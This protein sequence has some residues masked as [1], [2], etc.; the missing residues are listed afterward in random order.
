MRIFIECGISLNSIHNTG[1]QR[2]VRNIVRESESVGQQL[3]V[4]CIPVMFVS[5]SFR[6]YAPKSNRKG[7]LLIVLLGIFLK[8]LSKLNNLLSRLATKG[9]YSKLIFIKSYVRHLYFIYQKYHEVGNEGGV[10]SDQPLRGEV[11][12]LLDS[13]WDAQIWDA[14][15]KFRAEGGH[16]CA[17]LYDLI[18]FSHPETVEEHT[19]I[20]HTSWWLDAPLHIDSVMCISKA[21]RDD[22]FAWQ[23]E[24]DLTRKLM[25]EKVGYFHLGADLNKTDLVVQVLTSSAPNFLVVGSLEPRKNHNLILDAFEILWKKKYKINLVIVGAS[26]WKSEQLLDRIQRH[27]EIGHRLFIIRDASDRDLT[28]LY[29]KSEALIIASMVEGFG[30][31][32]VEAF[33]HGTQVICSDIPVFRE[34]AGDHAVYFEPTN[35]GALANK[36]SESV[37]SLRSGLYQKKGVTKEWISWKESTEQLLTR[38]LAITTNSESSPDL[39]GDNDLS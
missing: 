39:A 32:I 37:S 36:V 8:G 6:R 9:A 5:N 20:A 7:S 12:L 38:M 28:M 34:I 25:S 15:D 29:G 27:P 24:Q 30:L 35:A 1:I 26:S 33:Q 13:N 2:V 21:V 22:Y 31:P 3:G 4:E 10:I 23:E 14:V 18:P 11:L 16:V 17:A 19:R